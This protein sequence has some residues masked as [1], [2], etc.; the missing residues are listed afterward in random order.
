MATSLI[1][2]LTAAFD[3]GQFND[4]YR[5]ALLQII[6]KKVAGEVIE[7][8]AEPAPSK[9]VDLME[10]LKASVEAT[11]SK[12]AAAGDGAR[13]EKADEAP[14]ARRRKAAAS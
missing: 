11:R 9:V 4:E 6:E 13:A 3:P 8:P 14:P 10:A 7:V 5:A 2:N 12:G 1:E